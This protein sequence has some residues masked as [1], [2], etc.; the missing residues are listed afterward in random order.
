MVIQ[1][2]NYL[3]WQGYYEYTPKNV[4]NYVLKEPRLIGVY[5]LAELETFGRLIPFYVAQSNDLHKIL[6]DNLKNPPN[7]CVEKMLKEKICCFKFVPL[8]DEA[9]RNDALRDLFQQYNPKC[10]SFK[11]FFKD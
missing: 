4:K 8:L 9:K 10:N 5:K 7:E 3:R 6:L 2:S 1:P 11:N